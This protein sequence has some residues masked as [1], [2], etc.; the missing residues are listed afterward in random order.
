M[1]SEKGRF[2]QFLP[3]TPFLSESGF[4]GLSGKT[5]LA[6]QSFPTTG[7]LFGLPLWKAIRPESVARLQT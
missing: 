3:K 7:G 4:P 2:G 5:G 1:K 6:S